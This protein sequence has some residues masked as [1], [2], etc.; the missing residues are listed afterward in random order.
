[1]F[2]SKP[3][4]MLGTGVVLALVLWGVVQAVQNSASR[5][6]PS[7][8]NAENKTVIPEPI[9]GQ[10]ANAPASILSA[11]QDGVKITLQGTGVP[12]AG[13]SLQAGAQEQA[14]VKVSGEGAWTLAFTHSLTGQPIAYDLLMVTP[15][16]HQIRSDQSLIV[17]D[18]IKAATI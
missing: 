8:S 12:G 2:K 14:R 5:V 3:L 17:F 11:V 1:M 9:S 6:A 7:T 4:L 13:I 15:D 16:G 10:Y 18:L